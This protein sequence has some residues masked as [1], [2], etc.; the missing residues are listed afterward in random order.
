MSQASPQSIASGLS[1]TAFRNQANAILAAHYSSNSGA[2]AP[3]PTVAGM[4]WLDTGVSPAVFRL[5]NAA[6]TAWIAVS[7]ETAPAKTIR[8]NSGAAAAA[9]ADIAMT[10]LATMLGFSSTVADPGWIVLPGG[11]IVQWGLSASIA[12]GGSQTVTFPLA[13]PTACFRVLVSANTVANNTSVFSVG[14][15]PPTVSTVIIT[16]NSGTSGPVTASW[17]AIGN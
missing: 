17:I 15:R 2:T 13:F 1:G 3:S 12:A 8:G 5:R 7:P 6:N 14:A 11:L 9:I 4:A 16:N 10:T